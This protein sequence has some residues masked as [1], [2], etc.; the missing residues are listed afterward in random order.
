MSRMENGTIPPK[1]FLHLYW[2]ARFLLN[3]TSVGILLCFIPEYNNICYKG[4]NFDVIF[5]LSSCRNDNTI[6]FDI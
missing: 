2:R 4:I 3:K 1:P 6:T 5:L